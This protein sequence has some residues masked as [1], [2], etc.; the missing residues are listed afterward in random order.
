MT[1]NIQNE[2]ESQALDR[3]APGTELDENKIN[4]DRHKSKRDQHITLDPR[5]NRR[6]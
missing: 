3:L 4:K 2:K 1:N 5:E 6:M